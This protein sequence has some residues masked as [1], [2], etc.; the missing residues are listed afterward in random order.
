MG[1][2]GEAADGGER[3]GDGEAEAGG[4]GAEEDEIDREHEEGRD[5]EDDLGGEGR[6]GP[7]EHGG[8]SQVRQQQQ[9]QVQQPIQRSFAALRMKASKKVRE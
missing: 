5:D 8:L 3:G 6:V 1:D 9:E 2:R 7:K 4:A